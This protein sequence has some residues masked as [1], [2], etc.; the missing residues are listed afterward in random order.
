MGN[1]LRAFVAIDLNQETRASLCTLQ[2]ALQKKLTGSVS[3]VKPDNIHLTLRFLGHINQDQVKNIKTIIDVIAKKIKQFN[4]NLG[5]LGA[6]PNTANPRVLWVGIHYGFDELNRINAQ[7]EESLEAIHFGVG[8]KYFHPHMTIARIKHLDDNSILRQLT[9]QIK[10]AQVVSIV[11]SIMLFK[12]IS[13]AEGAV[14]E[15]L[16]TAKLAQ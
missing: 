1:E 10:P 9:Q 3:W 16:H 13:S 5:V 12:S 14:Y 11:D 15:K 7:L 4:I 6:F 2:E 8:E